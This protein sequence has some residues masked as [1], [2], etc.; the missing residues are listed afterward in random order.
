MKVEI[1][2]IISQIL[3]FLCMLW[4]L[5]R[6]AWK[7]IL[8]VME[9]R[10]QLIKSEFDTIDEEKRDLA[11]HVEDYNKKLHDIDMLA[12]SKVQ[13]AADKGRQVA[14]EIQDHALQEAKQIVHKARTDTQN[15]IV[16]AR[17][18]LKDELVNIT[19]QATEKVLQIDLSQEKQKKI[20]QDFVKQ[21]E[22]N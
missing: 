9:D 14:Q 12:Y 11:K 21:S 15:E 22:F 20:I 18:Q 2:Q 7:P 4:I 13:E 8:K 1:G 17:A 5:K 3:A 19:M 16:K 6:F 10:R